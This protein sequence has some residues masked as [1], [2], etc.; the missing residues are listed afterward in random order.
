MNRCVLAIGLA[1]ALGVGLVG[2]RY[3]HNNEEMMLQ[4]LTIST[5]ESLYPEAGFTKGVSGAFGGNLGEWT[6]YGGGCN[7][8][9]KGPSEGGIKKYYSSVYGV[10]GD[11]TIRIGELIAPLA[12][13][14]S[15]PSSDGSRLYFVGGSDGT[16]A[17][18]TIHEITEDGV[19]LLDIKLPSGW[20]EGSGAFTG[21]S[22][23]LA[24]GWKVDGVP[25]DSLVQVHLKT[26][27]H[28][29]IAAL[30]D[31]A[32]IQCVSFVLD[33]YFY[34]FGGHRPAVGFE[35]PPY[36]HEKAYRIHLNTENPQWELISERPTLENGRKLLFVGSTVAMEP[37][38]KQ[39]YVVGG[40]DWDIFEPAVMRGFN[41]SIATRDG[42]QSLLEQ[43][44]AE[45]KAYMSMPE[46]EYRFMPHVIR[47]VPATCG[48]EIVATDSAFATAGAVLA[49]SPESITVIGGER[50]P[51]V[52]TFNA[53]RQKI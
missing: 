26:G 27:E 42:N 1:A 22:L 24:G 35:Q 45:G 13:G 51:G 4:K 10:K 18:D 52:R 9:E 44:A 46:E 37:T 53:W 3:K 47:F 39:V 2:C 7:F 41:K 49:V 17:F 36:M 14:A 23:Y 20:F 5:D 33:D 32:R 38:T 30:P 43:Y 16:K 25:M 40:V 34:I 6:I 21:D 48:W 15:I 31:G 8:P 11:E 12:Y 50:K 28:K 19:K 29:A